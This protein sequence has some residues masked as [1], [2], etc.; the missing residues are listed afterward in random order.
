LE[1]EVLEEEVEQVG[2][3]TPYCNCRGMAEKQFLN[4]NII[5]LFIIFRKLLYLKEQI[6]AND[7]IGCRFYLIF[8]ATLF[9]QILWNRFLRFSVVVV[10][11]AVVVNDDEI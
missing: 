4:K 7:N 9:L 1:E 11:A 6:L 8:D 10:A 5:Q 3:Q 2:L